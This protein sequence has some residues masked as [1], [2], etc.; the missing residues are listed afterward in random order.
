MGVGLGQV[1]FDEGG[2]LQ[3]LS[4]PIWRKEL[5][6][7]EYDRKG[8]LIHKETGWY[9]VSWADILAG[10]CIIF[11]PIV[12]MQFYTQ[13]F[14]DDVKRTAAEKFVRTQLAPHIKGR[15]LDRAVANAFWGLIQNFGWMRPV[16][17]DNK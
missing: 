5:V 7:Y 3:A 8:N 17:P 16:L 1:G 13:V 15:E 14:T 6:D 11:G 4:R 10:A 12:L 2:V 9:D